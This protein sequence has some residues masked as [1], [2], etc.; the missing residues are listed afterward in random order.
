MSLQPALPPQQSRLS[1]VAE[2]PSPPL[3]IK[4]GLKRLSKYEQEDNS[5]QTLNM[6]SRRGSD[7]DVYVPIRRRSLLQPGV[8][9]RTSFILDDP[10]AT[11]PS[12]R[13]L[14]QEQHNNY[15]D[16]SKPTSSP[17][18]DLAILGLNPAFIVPGPRTETPTDMGYRHTG[19]FKLGFSQDHQW[20][21]KPYP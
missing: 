21:H 8:A 18:G 7:A 6:G 10:R 1:L 13:G 4:E 19:A 9:T 5:P 2:P 14:S 20:S 3:E 15:Y 12:Q 16:P 11:L 17:L